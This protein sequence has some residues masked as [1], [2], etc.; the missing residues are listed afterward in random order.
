MYDADFQCRL[1]FN[2]TDESV[3]VCDPNTICS[4]LWCRVNGVCSSKTMPA[5]SGTKCDKHKVITQNTFE[6]V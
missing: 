5:A 6:R 2:L 4:L 3:K 1:Q